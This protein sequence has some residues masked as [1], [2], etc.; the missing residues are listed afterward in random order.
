[1]NRAGWVIVL[2][3]LFA[4]VFGFLIS[5]TITRTHNLGYTNP[6]VVTVRSHDHTTLQPI[7]HNKTYPVR[8]VTRWRTTETTLPD[9]GG[10]KLRRH[11]AH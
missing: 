8:E 7:V 10:Q 6:Q 11:K 1:M 5:Y 2:M 9:T 3:A 4:F